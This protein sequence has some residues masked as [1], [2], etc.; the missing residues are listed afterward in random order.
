MSQTLQQKRSHECMDDDDDI[1]KST[2]HPQKF[3]C[4]DENENGNGVEEETEE[5]TEEMLTAALAILRPTVVATDISGSL[6]PIIPVPDEDL[7]SLDEARFAELGIE[8]PPPYR[9]FKREQLTP[10][11]L[12]FLL[13]LRQGSKMWLRMRTHFFGASDTQARVEPKIRITARKKEANKAEREE[14]FRFE[15]YKK[16]YITKSPKPRSYSWML[17]HGVYNEP[18]GTDLYQRFITSSDEDLNMPPANTIKC[19]DTLP[20]TMSITAETTAIDYDQADVESMRDYMRSTP[21]T[22]NNCILYASAEVHATRRVIAKIAA[23][24]RAGEIDPLPEQLL[25]AH[26]MYVNP[27]FPEFS[28]SPD[29]TVSRELVKH[30]PKHQQHLVTG[31]IE[32]KW[33]WRSMKY[34]RK[35]PMEMA[36]VKFDKYEGQLAQQLHLMT[37]DSWRDLVIC[38]PGRHFP[39]VFIRRFHRDSLK[40]TWDVICK[41]SRKFGRTVEFYD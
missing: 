12:D 13:H 7:D 5:V 17:M 32:I 14:Q 38:A 25:E 31:G 3:A 21:F 20:I 9:A 37:E 33:P 26:G 6:G 24:A 34:G 23:Q 11:L 41:S 19:Y 15:E 27:D 35:V 16:M 28:C 2:A 36:E 22:V 4:L 8:E 30:T 39:R 18:N 40:D 1:T 10:Q 29:G